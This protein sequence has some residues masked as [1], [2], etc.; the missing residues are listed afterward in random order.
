MIPKEGTTRNHTPENNHCK[1][2]SCSHYY[3]IQ[4]WTKAQWCNSF[5]PVMFKKATIWGKIKQQGALALLLVHW[6]EPSWVCLLYYRSVCTHPL[7]IARAPAYKT[8]NNMSTFREIIGCRC[9]MQ[10][11]C[12]EAFSQKNK[13]PL[14]KARDG[15]IYCSYVDRLQYDW[16]MYVLWA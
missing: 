15:T 4:K 6:P 10:H 5:V 8:L 9:G 16:L 7:T 2:R 3:K 13:Q 11:H 14:E 12:G 1:S